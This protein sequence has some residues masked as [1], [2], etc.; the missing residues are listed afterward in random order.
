MS[1]IV[2]RDEQSEIVTESKSSVEITTN[3]KGHVICKVK[4]Y[5][6]DPIKAANTAVELFDKL[7]KKYGINTRISF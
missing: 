1:L 4:I 7:K 2:K 3:S 6:D 5:D